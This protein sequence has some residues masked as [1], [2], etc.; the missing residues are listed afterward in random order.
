MAGIYKFLQPLVFV[1]FFILLHATAYSQS[2]GGNQTQITTDSVTIIDKQMNM[3]QSDKDGNNLA[4]I[5]EFISTQKIVWAIIVLIIAY[6]GIRLSIRVIGLF[7][8]KST[9]YRFTIKGLIPLFR[10]IAW[11]VTIVFIIAGIFAPTF[12]T[13]V[14]FSASVGVAVGFAAQDV[15]KNI[16]GGIMIIFDQPFKV[17]DKIE[18]GKYYGEVIEIGLRSTRI[19]TPDDSMVSVPNSEVM[20]QSVSNSNSGEP[21]CQVVAEIYLPITID[22]EKVRKIAVEA[23]QVSRYIYLD[24]PIS[25][26]FF[27]E[28]HHMQIFYKMR[29]KAYVMD[30]RFEFAFKSDMTELVVRELIRQGIIGE[31]YKL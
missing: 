14:A 2:A 15:L 13:V 29:L 31:P 17:G 4:P 27:Q 6:F 30:I 7:A 11:S 20:N 5:Y 1:S 19:V 8:E 26:L 24:K 23:A 12:A 25:V 16:F 21:N 22:T 18:I 9:K 3:E 28:I 10:I